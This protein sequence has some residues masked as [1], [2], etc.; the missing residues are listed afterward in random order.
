VDLHQIVDRVGTGDAFA[1][2]IVHGLSQRLPGSE[3]VEFA[4]ACSQWAHSIKG[5]FLRASLA[6]I[7]TMMAGSGDVSR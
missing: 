4:L 1:A 3:I 6:D 2:G 5:D 7:G